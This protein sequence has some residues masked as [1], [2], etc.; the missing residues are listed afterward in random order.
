MDN[1]SYVNQEASDAPS[2]RT[3]PVEVCA[4]LSQSKCRSETRTRV[5]SA[6]EH[7]SL[8]PLEQ[9]TRRCPKPA[10]GNKKR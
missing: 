5:T 2:A 8:A 4:A 7:W 1:S 3:E 6:F 10:E 9:G